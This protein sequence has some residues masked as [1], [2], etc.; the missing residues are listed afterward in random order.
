[1]VKHRQHGE[2]EKYDS[3]APEPLSEA[4]PHVYA[5]REGVD[6][7]IDC[8]PGGGKSRHGLEKGV[9]DVK[10][11]RAEHERQ[12]PEKGE[13]H[14]HKCRQQKTFALRHGGISGL[15]TTCHQHPGY[16]G[17]TEGV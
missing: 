9:G 3:H 17:D 6:R 15:D 14:P 16:E 10:R 4:T 11:G 12:H 1:M 7:L 5:V 13:Y 8:R 2:G